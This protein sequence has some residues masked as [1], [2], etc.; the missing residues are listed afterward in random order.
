[1]WATNN[2]MTFCTKGI[3]AR[4]LGLVSGVSQRSRFRGQVRRIDKCTS[5]KDMVESPYQCVCGLCSVCVGLRFARCAHSLMFAAGRHASPHLALLK[6]CGP[7]SHTSCL[8]LPE[9]RPRDGPELHSRASGPECLPASFGT[10]RLTKA[11]AAHN[12]E[13]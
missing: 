8:D 11:S 4:V 6:A 2:A 5:I 10:N 3:L 12:P 7:H 13:G 1:M 9:C